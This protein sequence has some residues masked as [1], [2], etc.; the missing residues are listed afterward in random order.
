MPKETEAMED[1]DDDQ[2]PMGVKG[3]TWYAITTYMVKHIYP[4]QCG[5]IAGVVPPCDSMNTFLSPFGRSLQRS[6][7]NDV[8]LWHEKLWVPRVKFLLL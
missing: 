2:Q 8:L 3:N 6:E 1:V 7:M 5:M 4:G